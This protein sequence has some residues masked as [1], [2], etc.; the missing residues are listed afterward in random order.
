MEL[1]NK[2]HQKKW[3]QGSGF[4]TVEVLLSWSELRG[5]LNADP[6]KL[7]NH[8]LENVGK[9]LPTR[10]LWKSAKTVFPTNANTVSNRADY[11][12]KSVFISMN[13]N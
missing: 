7:M 8:I 6:L 10:L 4:A 5:S 1:E 12:H 11:E 9:E 2:D 13:Y 3:T